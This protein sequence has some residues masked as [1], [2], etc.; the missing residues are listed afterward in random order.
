MNTPDLLDQ[1]YASIKT[2]RR[3]LCAQP[4]VARIEI[5]HHTV[6]GTHL[7]PGL[8]VD[9]HESSDALEA[10]ILVTRGTV[11]A[12]PVQVCFGMIP[13]S[14][15]QRIV[16]EI[17]I[18]DDARAAILA[19]CTFPNARSVRHEMDATLKIG[20]N[21]QYAYLERH[22]HGREGGV[23]VI[24]KSRVHVLEGARFST[25]FDLIKG[26]VGKLDIDVEVTCEAHAIMNVTANVSASGDDQVIIRE[27]ANLRGAHARGALKSHIALRCQSTAEVYNTIVASA[28]HVRG[29][30]DC[31]EIILDQARAKAIPV[32][33]VQ[34]PKAHVTH[35][36]AIGSVDDK[37]LE[38]LMSRG[39][40]E[41]QAAD[42]I[43]EGLLSGR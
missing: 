12:K 37:Q 41:D 3:Q 6:L 36:A 27:S 17:E 23:I 18:E 9:A 32:V 7:L 40:N 43:I 29:H 8:E 34:H 39:M 38:T 10:R 2:D 26:R 4:D 11:I 16:L 1:L 33:D 25:D 14:G 31:K 5:H 30:V 35:E 20:R 15:V 42:L 19:H 24:P 21:A 13:E 22:V 28:P